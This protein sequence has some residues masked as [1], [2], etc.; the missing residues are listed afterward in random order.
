[1]ARAPC[2]RPCAIS[3]ATRLGRRAV[4]VGDVDV[5]AL[6][7]EQPWRWRGRCRRRRRSPARCGPQDV[8]S[9]PRFLLACAFASARRLRR[10]HP[11]L[12]H[13]SPAPRPRSDAA[14]WCASKSALVAPMRMAIAAICTISAGVGPEH[15]AADARGPLSPSTTQLHQH[16]L[17]AARQRVLHRA[18]AR[19]VD[20]EL[21]DSARAPRAR[22]GRRCRSRAWRTR[23]SGSCRG[24]PSPACCRTRCRRRRGPRG[25]RPASG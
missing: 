17:V 10:R 12:A 7:R 5:G 3:P 2:R 13:A 22:S 1:M 15:V 4:D 25:W 16:A 19:L 14:P 23:R 8:S 11:L 18:E 6:G 9:Q 24:R 20:V 21:G